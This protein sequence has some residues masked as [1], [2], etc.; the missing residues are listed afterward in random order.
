MEGDQ[1]VEDASYKVVEVE[2]KGRGLVAAKTLNVGELV[3]SEKMF[4]KMAAG[5]EHDVS[6][7]ARLNKET[8]KK[9]MKLSC[10]TK[11]QESEGS[12]HE[13][14]Q[15]KF[16]TNCIPLDS[17]NQDQRP[18]ESAVFETISMINHSCAPNVAWFTEEMD[19]TRREV[20]VCRHIKEGEEILASYIGLSEF[21]LRQE[22]RD[23]LMTTWAFVCRRASNFVLIDTFVSG[24]KSAHSLGM[25]L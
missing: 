23:S 20:R 13:I 2:G 17:D 22:R 21:P 16:L 15:M 10:P 8:K 18:A 9:L 7:F 14:L 12:V 11:P 3:V 6:S 24:V 25:H 5:S 1:A 19:K 4:L